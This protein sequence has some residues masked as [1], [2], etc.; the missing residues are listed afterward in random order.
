MSYLYSLLRSRTQVQRLVSIN[1]VGIAV[2][3]KDMTVTSFNEGL[4]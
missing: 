4:T 2:F 1:F 3:S